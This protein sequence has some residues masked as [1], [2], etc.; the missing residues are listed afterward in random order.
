MGDGLLLEMMWEYER[1]RIDL[2]DM[3]GWRRRM[4]LERTPPREAPEWAA[5]ATLGRWAAARQRSRSTYPG[6]A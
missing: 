5:R 6:A 3:P 1:R 2:I 4:E